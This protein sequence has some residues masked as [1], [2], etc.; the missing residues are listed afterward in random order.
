MFLRVSAERAKHAS[1]SERVSSRETEKRWRLYFLYHNTCEPNT[2]NSHIESRI[3]EKFA[4]VPTILFMLAMKLV[5]RTFLWDF[6]SVL[7]NSSHG[8]DTM[9]K[10]ISQARATSSTNEGPLWDLKPP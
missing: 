2:G 6:I 3:F 5:V 7:G 8:E 10:A 9:S 4:P 1:S